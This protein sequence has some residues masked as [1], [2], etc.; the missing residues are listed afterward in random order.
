MA[1]KLIRLFGLALVSAVLR[2]QAATAEYAISFIPPSPIAGQPVFARLID[3]AR[4]LCSIDPAVVAR[5]QSTITLSIRLDD[6]SCPPH[7]VVEY[8]DIALGVLSAGTYQVIVRNCV[9]D[10]LPG[11]QPCLQQLETRLV[12]G[13]KR[14][15]AA[16]TFSLWGALA[17]T[18]G[19]VIFGWR[20]LP[21]RTRND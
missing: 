14:V 9:D 1:T 15:D 2:V 12:V 18:L 3:D 17:V 16:P 20:A 5:E 13:A 21:L 19:I 8:R 4:T 7:N 11:A 10:P 6:I